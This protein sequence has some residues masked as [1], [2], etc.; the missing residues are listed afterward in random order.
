MLN[1]YD[2]INRN[3]IFYVKEVRT[4]G[5]I[6]ALAKQQCYDYINK[7]LLESVYFHKEQ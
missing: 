5:H 1:E 6:V 2:N 4:R 3:I 7:L